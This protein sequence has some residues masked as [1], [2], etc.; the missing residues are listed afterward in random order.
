MNRACI[1][2]LVLVAACS[3]TSVLAQA[4]AAASGPDESYRAYWAAAPD[5]ADPEQ[6]APYL[7]EDRLAEYRQRRESDPEMLSRAAARLREAFTQLR[8]VAIEKISSEGD[9]ATI[10]V[11]FEPVS[12]ASA[13]GDRTLVR[14]E[15][16]RS[17][18]RWRIHD[19]RM[20]RAAE[21]GADAPRS[22][23]CPSTLG[24]SGLTT[25]TIRSDSGTREIRFD[26][27]LVLLDDAE[28]Q[29]RLPRFAQNEYTLVVERFVPARAEQRVQ[30]FGQFVWT[31]CMP[32]PDFDGRDRVGTLTIQNG[33][34][35][36]L[37]GTFS[38]S[39][40]DDPQLGFFGVVRGR[41][42]D[43]GPKP[44]A[45]G[46]IVRHR[47]EEI[48]ATRSTV[49]YHPESS[50][51]E[52][53]IGTA[54]SMPVLSVSIREFSGLPGVYRAEPCVGAMC[55]VFPEDRAL[56]A[57]VH[58]F[59][60]GRFRGEVRDVPKTAVANGLPTLADAAEL[61][62]LRARFE[63]GHVVVIPPLEP[64]ASPPR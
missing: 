64:L 46:S 36:A 40:P 60:N 58:D 5:L 24:H 33:D 62:I 12:A 19:E 21:P 49:H 43:I 26:E 38:I 3:A 15:M 57:M 11:H 32:L 29:I 7:S 63:T 10:R 30:L 53:R 1:K 8:I 2:L 54:T 56:L 27:A 39:H 45:A 55:D 41:I 51:L 17:G 6:M 23:P 52:A 18:G 61:G 31:E 25:L 14:V 13:T 16:R 48:P 44:T 37:E 59:G 35:A 4:P 22:E 47:D 28:L 42:T 9:S 20:E 34:S 50:L